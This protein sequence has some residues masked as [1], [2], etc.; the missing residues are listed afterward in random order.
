MKPMLIATLALLALS[1]G[2][3]IWIAAA[4]TPYSTALLIVHKLTAVAFAVLIVILVIKDARQTGMTPM[5]I[6]LLAALAAA[7]LAL[8]ATGGIL[9]AK[10][11]PSALLRVIHS[12]SAG[13]LTLGAGWKLLSLLVG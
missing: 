4:G 2:L 12:V 7:L 13:I 8:L 1:L 10:Q 5:D 3:G 6:A 9:S 11:Q